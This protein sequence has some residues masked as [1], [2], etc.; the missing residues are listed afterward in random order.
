MTM[1]KIYFEIFGGAKVHFSKTRHNIPKLMAMLF[2]AILI[3]STSAFAQGSI[4][5]S[6]SNSDATTPANGEISFFGYL[7]DTDEEIRIETCVG[8]GYDGGNWYDDFQNY[9]TE[10]A[11]NPYDYHFYNNT[12]GEGFVLSELIPNNSFQQEDIT[13]APVSWPAKPTGLSGRAVSGSSVVISWNGVP[14]LTYHVYRREATSDGSLFRIDDPSGLL[15]NPG[16]ADSFYVDNTVDGVSSYDYMIIPEDISGNLGEHS[17]VIVV[18]SSTLEAPVITA[19]APDSG[20]TYGGTA[21]TISGTGFDVNG[22]AVDIGSGVLTS[23][24]IVSPFE[25]TGLTPSGAEGSVDVTVTNTASALTSIPLTGGFTYVPNTPPVLDPIG[26]QA[27]TEN[28]PLIFQVTS[29]D[30]DGTTPSLFTSALPGTATFLDNGDG[31]G[32]FN[33]TPSYTDSGIYNVTFYSADDVDTVFEDVA[34]TVTDAGNQTPV[35]DSIGSRTVAENFNLNFNITSSD[36]DED[37]IYLSADNLPL[38]AA[39]IDSGNGIG[40][41]DFNPDF[42]QEGTYFVTFKAFDGV[43]VDSEVVQIDVTHINQGPVLA[44]IGPQMTDEQVRLFFTISATD[45]DADSLILSTSTL[46]GTAIF[47]DSSN[48]V[49]S[50]D[51]TPSYT[52]AGV[53]DVMFYVFDG[54]DTDSELVTITINDAGNQPPALD[55]IGSISLAEGDTLIR[56][57]TASD[58]DGDSVSLFADSLPTNATFIDSGNGVGTFTFIPDFT[59]AGAYNVLFYASDGFLNDSELVVVTV[60]ESGNQP[61]IMAVVPDTVIDEGDSLVVVV[62]AYDP[63]GSGVLFSATSTLPIF[64]FIDSGNGVGVFSFESDYYDAGTDTVWFYAIDFEVPPAVAIDT[65]AII[66]NDINRPPVIDSIGPYGVAVDDTLIFNVTASDPTDPITGH[67][68]FLTAVGAPTNSHFVDNGNNSGT[69]TFYPD[70]TQTGPTSVTFIATDMGTPQL[71]DNFAVNITVVQ[72]N[73]PPE[74]D[75]LGLITALDVWEGGT[76]ELRV[77]ATDADGGIPAL[78][79]SKLPE[80]ATFV[81]SG[82]GAG[83]FT[84][85]PNFVQSGLYEAILNAYD[86]I[87]VTDAQLLIQVYEAGNQPPEFNPIPP[88]SVVEGDTLI[89]TISAFDPDETIPAL[90]ADSL[91]ENATFTDNGDGTGTIEFYPTYIQSRNYYVYIFADDGEFIDTVVITIV[92]EEA[93][94][95]YPDLELPGQQTVDENTNLTF[96]INSSDPD[97]TTPIL[98]AG[99]MPPGASF[100]DNNDYTGTFSWT[101]GYYDEGSYTVWFYATDSLDPGMVDSIIVDITVNNVNQLPRYDMTTLQVTVDEGD[102]AYF[103]FEV[104]DPD[105]PLP[106][107][108][109]DTPD[110]QLDTTFMTFV[111]SGNG[112]GWLTLIPGP[113]V[114]TPVQT[115]RNFYLRWLVIDSEDS[116]VMVPTLQATITV[117]HVNQPPEILTVISDTIITE[118]QSLA[119]LVIAS[120]FDGYA[121]SLRA[122][123]LPPNAT[124]EGVVSYLKTFTFEPDYLQAG[125]YQVTFIAADSYYVANVLEDTAIMNITV[126]EAGNQP[127]EFTMDL[128]LYQ[129]VVLG[130]TLIN[131]LTAV[132]PEL[133]ALTITASRTLLNSTFIDSGNGAA[134]FVFIPDAIQYDSLFYFNFIVQDPHGAADTIITIYRVIAAIRGD[135]NSDGSLNTLDVMYLINFLYKNGEAPPVEDAADVNNDGLINLMDPTYMLNFLYL[136]GPAPPPN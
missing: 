11:G 28:I 115:F 107:I 16:V 57:I 15:S 119:F 68:L 82:N 99:S 92:V 124:F 101:P 34:I 72:E 127:P 20:S 19:I 50:F 89:M 25:I 128:D 6:V 129:L 95:Q 125:S 63:D 17:D 105:G 97:M 41:F 12:N 2:F 62:S 91:P 46:P 31:T 103:T 35:L 48:G 108:V 117:Q 136:S 90:S 94:N 8:A 51:W 77:S 85:T 87:D 29:S 135:A 79:A 118:G 70:S 71:T 32:D 122:E 23:V 1:N 58:A 55:S 27:T 126:L 10:A 67:R 42:T 121:P 66:I 81:D 74:W 96:T 14:G 131:H 78:Y 56:N 4:Y 98:S 5:G 104:M 53:Y 18:N 113:E 44:A 93:G 123:G 43:E 38:N 100:T 133:E 9:L 114:V 112:W 61:P 37:T 116:A 7:D 59:Q 3:S 26:P 36:A 39:F 84:F 83:L 64:T 30:P 73:N 60:G 130:D 45:G 102:T 33:W 24:V 110:F 132:D 134:S 40:N 106:F 13:I 111:D 69:F 75:S 88:D 76:L 80:N 49:G 47:T 54:T 120:D 86:G 52:D 65:M 21:I 109:V 22:A